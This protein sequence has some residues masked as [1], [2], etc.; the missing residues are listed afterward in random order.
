MYDS[1]SK[2]S[3]NHTLECH[4]L[5]VEIK[6]DEHVENIQCQIKAVQFLHRQ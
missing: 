1:R 4:L 5:Y 3:Y 6:W 2:L